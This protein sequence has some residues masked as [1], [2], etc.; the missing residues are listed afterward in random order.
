MNLYIL[1]LTYNPKLKNNRDIDSDFS[2]FVDVGESNLVNKSL[3][4][5]SPCVIA[6]VCLIC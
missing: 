4:F 2:L 6:Y 5:F 1:K 3:V